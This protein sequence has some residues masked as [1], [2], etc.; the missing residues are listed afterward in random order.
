ME[1][2]LQVCRGMLGKILCPVDFSAGSNAALKLAVRLAGANG[3]ELVIAHAFQFP[4]IAATEPM[5]A[6][7]AIKLAEEGEKRSL[8]AAG[9]QALALGATRVTTRF[10]E[11]APWH[12]LVG[13]VE[14]EHI[15]LV[16]MGTHG[17]TGLKRWLIGSVAEKVVRHAAASVLVVRGNPDGPRFD[18][19]LCPIDFADDSS[20]IVERV[21][22]F[23][24]PNGAGIELL[25]AIEL[26]LAASGDPLLA[27]FISDVDRRAT[28][29][30][31]T[32][33]AAVKARRQIHVHA[34]VLT[35]NTEE[36]ILAKL[37]EDRTFDLVAVGA[38]GRTGIKR[39]LGSVA[40]KLV[41]HSPCSVL[42]VRARP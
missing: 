42:V 41:R 30:L 3:S 17:R 5:M 15:D 13:L 31:E 29:Q 9:E 24:D 21:E 34:E 7:R 28:S 16:V 26:P 40:E 8:A 11:G 33:V 36:L 38:H 37:E 10:L 2:A 12:E 6:G 1:R 19:V 23:A 22:T 20:R 35:G 27:D 39:F 14:S 32:Y 25:H 4:G 18:H